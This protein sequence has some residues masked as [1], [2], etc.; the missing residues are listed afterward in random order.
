M[1]K[2]IIGLINR[3][4]TCYLNTSIQC[5]SNI[6]PFTDYVISDSFNDDLRNRFHQTKSTKIKEIV[7]SREWVKLIKALWQT[8]NN[9]IEPK[10]LHELLQKYDDRFSGYEQQDSQEALAFILDYLHEAVQYDVDIKY[11][12]IVQNEVD[13]IMIESIKNWKKELRD[14]YSIVVELFFGQFINK[15]M[16]LEEHN[17]NQMVSKTFEVFNMLNIP[18]YG[19]TLYDSL[20]KYFE[21]EILETKYFNENTNEHI[22]AYRQIKLMRIPKYLIIVLKRYRNQ[23]NGN[24]SKSNNI[25][26]FP[27]DNLDLTSYCEGYDGFDCN[28]RLISVGCHRGG[29][30]GGHYFAI[31]RHKNSKWYKYDDDTVREFNI[32]RDISSLFRDGYI[33]IYEKME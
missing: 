1:D 23:T 16:S 21:K 28:M 25:I 15:V 30:N 8:N 14:K 13:E 20:A 32:H 31:C 5:L 10:S 29:L 33:L 12:G 24:L 27:I 19:K 26:T 22:D 7:F 17:K 2:G 4:N 6:I 3:G 11:S 9:A 18:I